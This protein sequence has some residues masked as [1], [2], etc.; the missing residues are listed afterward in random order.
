VAAVRGDTDLVFFNAPATPDGAVRHL[1]PVPDGFG[2]VI[3]VDAAAQPAGAP[4]P[5]S[6]RRG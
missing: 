5:R 3:A 2:E 4:S 6:R 1:G